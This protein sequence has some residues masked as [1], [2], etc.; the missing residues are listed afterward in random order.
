M[1]ELKVVS[2]GVLQVDLSTKMVRLNPIAKSCNKLVSD[3]LR[4]QGT[5]DLICEF[6][7]SN[8]VMGN[9]IT[10]IQGGR[11]SEQGTWVTKEL[12]IAFMMWC[13]P[14]FAVGCLKKLDELF[15]TGET[16]LQHQAPS[17]FKEALLLAIEQQEKIEGLETQTKT[18][19][20]ELD[21]SQ[22]WLTIKKVAFLN[23]LTWQFFDWKILKEYSLYNSI[24]NFL[25]AYVPVSR[26]SLLLPEEF[27]I[28]CAFY[29]LSNIVRYNPSA[30]NMLMDSKY[31]P[32][33][34][35][36]QSHG[37]YWFLLLFYR[38][39]MQETVFINVI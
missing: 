26:E 8:A 23:N 33:I 27:P 1:N 34:L 36:L 24:D 2:D 32:V 29:H 13:S 15:T 35:A 37:L 7:F 16:K 20:I 39:M 11:P 38:Y 28:L 17:T 21:Q 10:T 3:W 14:S 18:L 25:Y 22:D 12:A 5:Q 6:Q 4:L 9:P 31:W 19:E 30:L